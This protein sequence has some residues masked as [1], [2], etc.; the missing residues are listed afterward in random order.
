MLRSLKRMEKINGKPVAQFWKEALARQANF[1]EWLRLVPALAAKERLATVVA[2]VKE[3]NPDYAGAAAHKIDNGVVTEISLN[4][5]LADLAP[6]RAL[7]GLKSFH[8]HGGDLPGG[9]LSDLT[10]LAGM[11]LTGLYLANMP[12]HDL[13]PLKGMPLTSLTFGAATGCKICRRSR[14]CRSPR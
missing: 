7:P 13:S 12:V 4:G 1:K 14:A 2:K 10:P 3:H 5:K 11:K 8:T 6:L 9:Y